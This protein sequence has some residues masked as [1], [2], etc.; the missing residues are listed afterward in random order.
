MFDYIA[1][2][3]RGHIARVSRQLLKY[4]LSFEN[5]FRDYDLTVVR[6]LEIGIIEWNTQI[7]DCLSQVGG[8]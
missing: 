4:C 7:T 6:D 8:R 1:F 2:R 3:L 5:D